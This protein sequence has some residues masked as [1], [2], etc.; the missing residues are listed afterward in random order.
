MGVKCFNHVV[1]R[2]LVPCEFVD[3]N[4]MKHVKFSFVKKLK[5]LW[6]VGLFEVSDEVYP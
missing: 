4:F 5:K 6:C 1:E 2:E 3:F